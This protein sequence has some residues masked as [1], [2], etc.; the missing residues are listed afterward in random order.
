MTVSRDGAAIFSGVVACV[1]LKDL[2]DAV[3]EGVRALLRARPELTKQAPL[4][5]LS[6]DLTEAG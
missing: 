6:I 1:D 3:A 5:A 2:P 4:E